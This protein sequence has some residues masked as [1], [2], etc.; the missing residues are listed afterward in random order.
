LPQ[1]AQPGQAREAL[2]DAP[3]NVFS[4]CYGIAG[5]LWSAMN[6]RKFAETNAAGETCFNIVHVVKG[7]IDLLNGDNEVSR[8][9]FVHCDLKLEN[10]VTMRD[11]TD[12]IRGYKI[13]HTDFDSAAQLPEVAARQVACRAASA[14]RGLTP[15]PRSA[16]RIP[17]TIAARR[18]WTRSRAA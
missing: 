6:E 3:L 13:G 16:A 12:T 15:G 9:G 14:A 2:K 7:C 11:P 1:R 4:V 10:A 5:D 8:H 17:T 18:I